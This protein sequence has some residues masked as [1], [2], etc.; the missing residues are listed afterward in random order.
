LI[1]GPPFVIPSGSSDITDK[2][3]LLEIGADDYLT[4][5]FNPKELIARVR[6]QIRRASRIR[7]EDM[8][9]LK[10]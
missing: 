4:E 10:T 3:L 9:V 7:P 1:P 5:P 6:A 8:Y 2:I